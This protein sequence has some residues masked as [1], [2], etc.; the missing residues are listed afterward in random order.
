M[1]ENWLIY[2]LKSKPGHI[3]KII[4]KDNPIDIPNGKDRE[5]DSW[6]IYHR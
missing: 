5:E 1:T 3:L 2:N 6:W 4:K